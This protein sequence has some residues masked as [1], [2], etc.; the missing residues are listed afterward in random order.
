MKYS[1]LHSH[2]KACKYNCYFGTLI[3]P[4]SRFVIVSTVT[5]DFMASQGVYVESLWD[6]HL[7]AKRR[8]AV[9]TF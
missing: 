4:G 9:K 2:L 7:A 5:L 3:R 8:I 6:D 1:R